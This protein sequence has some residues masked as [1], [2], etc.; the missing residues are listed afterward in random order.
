MINVWHLLWILPLAVCFG[1]FLASI[2]TAASNAD[3]EIER[4]ERNT[5]D[6][7]E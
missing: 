4:R 1:F 5:Y 7:E 3:D 2:L 6:Y